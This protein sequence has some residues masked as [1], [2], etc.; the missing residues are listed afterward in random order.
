MSEHHGLEET[1]IRLLDEIETPRS[2]KIAFWLGNFKTFQ[3][4]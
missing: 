2:K 3:G 1:S 4:N